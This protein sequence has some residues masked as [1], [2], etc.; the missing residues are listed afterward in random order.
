MNV[1]LFELRRQVGGIAVQT[2][3]LAG[4]LALL[5]LG[6]YPIYA[7]AEDQVRS[8]LQGFPPE[9]AA[10]FGLSLDK[11]FS[12]GGFYAFGN[13][14]LSLVGAIFAAS[15][16][17]AVF[18][19]EKRATCTDFLLTK[20]LGRTGAFLAKLL[21][22]VTG[23]V[24]VNA[25]YVTVAVAVHAASGDTS[26]TAGEVALASLG[27]AGT[28]AVFLSLGV[29]AATLLR[30][31]RSVSGMASVLGFG[32]FV[33]SALVNLTEEEALRYVSPL[34]Y[35]DP[36]AVF[37]NGAFDPAYAATAAAVMVVALV[38]SFVKYRVGDVSSR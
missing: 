7:G 28:Q 8:V 31:V 18:A 26:A 20:P 12:Y 34:Q 16:A 23:L 5:M 11:L 9:F 21:A 3:V 38:V 6:V 33:L 30:R 37:S 19:R 24:V 14:Y 25:V 4:L 36:S 17:L 29:L 32:G 15:L 1:Y 13:L 22:C 10:A 27:L 2:V 35:F